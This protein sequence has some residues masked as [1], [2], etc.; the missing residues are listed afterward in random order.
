[1]YIYLI[2][3]IH[4]INKICFL[5]SSNYLTAEIDPSVRR[6]S[7]LYNFLTMIISER[8]HDKSHKTD[9]KIRKMNFVSF[10]IFDWVCWHAS[11]VRVIQVTQYLWGDSLD[12]M[13]WEVSYNLQ[14][15]SYKSR[16]R[17]R[18]MAEGLRIRK[19]FFW[20]IEHEIS[21]S[22]RQP[23]IECVTVHL[24]IYWAI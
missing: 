7:C 23:T 5:C 1:M 11:G 17:A 13:I 3:A 24:A 8:H 10:S 18:H 20:K 2:R 6:A 4:L 21:F 16:E 15:R 22:F 19:L 14:L 12:A 9:S